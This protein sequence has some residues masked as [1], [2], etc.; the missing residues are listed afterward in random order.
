[1]KKTTKKII[2]IAIGL[3]AVGIAA[4]FG[5]KYYDYKKNNQY[6]DQ[7]DAMKRR[8]G[9]WIEEH[10]HQMRAKDSKE[11]KKDIKDAL[12]EYDVDVTYHAPTSDGRCGHFQVTIKGDYDSDD[13]DYRLKPVIDKHVLAVDNDS[14]GS[15]DLNADYDRKGRAC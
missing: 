7:D 13:V 3:T 2:A 9:G 5:V 15:F 11:I 1:M 8:L 14:N 10:G 6:G 4:Y 12:P